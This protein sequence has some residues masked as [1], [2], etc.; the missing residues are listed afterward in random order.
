[1]LV[2]TPPQVTASIKVRS[3]NIAAVLTNLEREWKKIYG[4]RPFT[5]NFLDEKYNRQYKVDEQLAA[6]II[7]FTGLALVVACL[8]LFALSSF[9]VSRRTKEIGI[10]KSMGASVK[11]IYVLLSWDFLKWI[12]VAALVACPVA[13]FLLQWWLS[14]FAY[15]IELG[16]SIFVLAAF[17]ALCVSLLTVTWQSLKAATAN[18]IKVLRYE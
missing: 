9:M 4:D 11:S 2:H 12:F 1:M 10:R 13:W 7:W 14:K 5:F 6:I 16:T 17:L 8:G 18:P 15:H 3:S